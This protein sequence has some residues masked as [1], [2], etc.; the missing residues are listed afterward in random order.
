M[1]QPTHKKHLD[2]PIVLGLVRATSLFPI[3]HFVDMTKTSAQK[4]TH[5][6][7]LQV[8]TSIYKTKG[9]SGFADG[10]IP[11]FPRRMAR[12]SIRWPVVGYTYHVLTSNFPNTF[13]EKSTTSSVFSGIAAASFDALVLGPLE[14]LMAFKIKEGSR[15]PV[16]FQRNRISS[17]YQGALVN[18]FYRATVWSIYMGMNREIEKKFAV[19][20]KETLPPHF[21]EIVS[22]IS[23]ATTL[24]AVAMPLD[25]LKT[26]I[27]MDPELQN[28]KITFAIQK[29]LKDHGFKR[30]YA[31]APIAWSYNI[32]YGFVFQKMVQKSIAYFKEH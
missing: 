20:P 22:T 29:L 31:G 26:R 3:E 14:N 7:S 19:L 4:F 9:L 2:N 11:N 16:F 25:F 27:Q 32:I 1:T 23:I 15:Y 28:K 10:A 8:I 30:F 21:Q 13:P 24:V 12:D 6:T 17:L 18:L 5:L